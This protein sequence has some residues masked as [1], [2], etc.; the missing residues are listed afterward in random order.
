MKGIETVRRD[1]CKLTSDTMTKVL[2]TVL[3][4]NDVKKATRYVR[5]V[6]LQL[7]KGNIPIEKLTIVKGVTKSLESYEGMQPHVELAKK[8]ISRDPTKTVIGERLEFVIVKGNQIMSKRAE[9][10]EYVKENK[11][12]IDSQYYI[13]NQLLPPLERILEACGVSTSELIEGS[14]QRN[15]LDVLNGHD[16]VLSPQEIILQGFENVVCKKCDWSFRR[17][18]LN[19]LCPNCSGELYFA[20]GGSIGKTVEF[21]QFKPQV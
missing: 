17:P 3:K 6:I 13:E 16:K 4:E 7:A 21:T 5:D 8:I 14:K 11:L 15:L 9:D 19:G 1:W 20:K 10:P 18:T 12:E 2:E